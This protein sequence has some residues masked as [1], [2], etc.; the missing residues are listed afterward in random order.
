MRNIIFGILFLLGMQ[1]HA[2]VSVTFQ[3]LKT[4]KNRA[5]CQFVVK[6]NSEAT[7]GKDWHLYFTQMPLGIASRDP[8]VAMKQIHANFYELQPTEAWSPLE[9]G[10]TV[11]IPVAIGN[12][13]PKRALSPEGMFMVIGNGAPK[14]VSYQVLPFPDQEYM[15]DTQYQFDVAK[16]LMP[17]RITDSDIIPSVKSATFT[18]GI[19]SLAKGIRLVTD[20][21]TASEG[22]LLSEKLSSSYGIKYVAKGL[23]I[24]LKVNEQ[25]PSSNL[26]YYELTISSKG[27]TISGKSSHAV[28]DGCQ[29]LIA[30]LKGKGGNPVSLR[31]MSIKD[32]PDLSYRGMMIDIARDFTSSTNLMK[33]LDVLASYKINVLQFHFCDDEGWRLE[34][35]GLPELTDFG[36]RRGYTLD[37]KKCLFPAYD[38][39]YDMKANT[40]GN[41]YY[42]R[43]EFIQLLKYAQA[44]HIQV[45]PEV[46]CPGHCRAAI[47]S[48]QVRYLKYIQSDPKKATEYL[49]HEDGDTSKYRSAQGYHDNILNI[50]MPSSLAF[51]KKVINELILM[52]QEAGVPLYNINLGGDE[53]PATSWDGSRLCQEYMKANHLTNAEELSSDFY[54]K[55]IR[56]LDEKGL[57]YGGWQEIASRH[58]PLNKPYYHQRAYGV[59]AWSTIP[60]AGDDELAYQMANDGYPVVIS[61]VNNFYMD[62][63]YNMNPDE[64]GLVWGGSVD[65]TKSFAM[66]P[67]NVYRAVH[68]YMDNRPYDEWKS[69]PVGKTKLTEKGKKNIIGVQG[70]L[71]AETI[72]GYNWVEYYLFPKVMGLA[73]R[74]WNASPS[75]GNVEGE[76]GVKAYYKALS[77]F[78]EVIS[79]KEMPY[80]EKNKVNFRVANPGIA[81]KDGQVLM[82]SV[83]DGAEIR[84]TTDGS[85]P[86]STSTLYTGPFAKPTS[87]VIKARAFKEGK[88]SVISVWE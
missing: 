21:K 15:P 86:S 19:C 63:A 78:E 75:W 79:K 17:A 22:I 3:K 68:Y 87:G 46:E 54:A 35:P 45:I 39:N 83:V 52:Y 18:K 25:L 55:I 65:E 38:G 5:F 6:N 14:A 66:L 37:E 74:G 9:H 58:R 4:Q 30:L 32:Y 31:C 72:R 61:N 34:I 67:Y 28:F 81:V 11:H 2:Q 40:P 48:M 80:W 29:T 13:L 50:A 47:K 12:S 57:K 70:Q 1:A 23:P 20:A 76:E 16:N 27:I 85:E 53:V 26:E 33:L 84:Y 51:V 56:F 42:T 69:T 62:L 10:D 64:R 24:T 82:N 7:L 60:F 73:E 43:A 88:Q 71:W 44:R 59:M 36:S 49:L 41:G 8:R 77:A